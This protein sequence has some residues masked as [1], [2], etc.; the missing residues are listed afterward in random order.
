MKTESKPLFLNGLNGIRAIGA[1]GVLFSHLNLGL[2]KHFEIE[3]VSLFGVN[4]NG[5]NRS[6]V[7]GEHGVTMFFVLSGFLIT[8]LLVKEFQ[9]TGSIN[10]RSFYVRRI[11]RIWPLY[12]FYLITTCICL[13]LLGICN[14]GSDL[15]FYTF[16]MANVPFGL[17]HSHEALNH[18]WSI[19]V[20]EQFYLFW[21]VAFLWAIRRNRF[22]A[23]SVLAIGALLVFRVLIWYKAPFS[24]PAM[25]SVVNRFDCMLIGAL[26]AWVYLKRENW[27]VIVDNML[28]QVC[29]WAI[30]FLLVFNKFQVLNSIIEAFIITLVTTCII[31]GQINLKNRIVNL[32]L[33]PFTYL[34]KL[35]FGIYV[36][37]PL[38]ILLTSLFL[39]HSYFPAIDPRVFTAI[40]YV[41][42]LSASIL[43]SHVSYYKFELS[44]LKMKSKFSVVHSTNTKT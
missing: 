40:V 33:A 36:Y 43:I 29:C 22:L 28:A 13:A 4:A 31:I 44:F 38:V 32:E 20:E 24:I 3:G 17:G 5:D 35:S 34:G 12:Y 2:N 18:L 11:L 30:V 25:F 41:T 37:H 42:V 8:Y 9:K 26:G 7:L 27:L 1:L 15:F 21:P 16:Y 23:L 14:L 10:I 6:W 39:K 19:G